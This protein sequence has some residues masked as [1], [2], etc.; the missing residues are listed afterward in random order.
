MDGLALARALH[1][2]GVVVGIGGVAMQLR[3]R[4]PPSAAA[5]TVAWN[6]PLHR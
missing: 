1:V 5:N 4:F 3:W 2:L 6:D